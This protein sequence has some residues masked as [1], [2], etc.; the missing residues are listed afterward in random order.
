MHTLC[1][2]SGKQS[3]AQLLILCLTRVL[4]QFNLP[5][6]TSA[7]FSRQTLAVLRENAI[8][9]SH[10]TSSEATVIQVADCLDF[11]ATSKTVQLDSCLRA[12]LSHAQRSSHMQLLGD[13]T[14]SAG[15]QAAAILPQPIAAHHTAQ[16]AVP[17]KTD[18]RSSFCFM[19]GL[20]AQL[21]INP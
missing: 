18:A 15:R 12:L 14:R 9:C 8:S 6:G 20:F 21:P 11:A 17:P 7:L 5:S 2:G 19:F 3:P 1:H 4:L 10:P 16:R 13:A